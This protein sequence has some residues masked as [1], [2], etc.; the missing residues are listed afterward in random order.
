MNRTALLL[1]VV[2]TLII[3]P[4]CRAQQLD[5]KTTFERFCAM[6]FNGGDGNLIDFIICNPKRDAMERKKYSEY[7]SSRRRKV[8][9]RNIYVNFSQLIVIS[10]Y[11]IQSITIFKT[12]A[13][14]VVDFDRLV[15]TS[16]EGSGKRRFIKDI[17]KH[18]IVKYQ[19]RKVGGLWYVYDPPL[20]RV[21]IKPVKN[22]FVTVEKL[23]Q[24]NNPKLALWYTHERQTL[25]AVEIE[26]KSGIQ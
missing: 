26:V 24:K 21:S 25:E 13:T 5:P 3:F 4:E 20:P 16:G 7:Y 10:T 15:S 12:T 11:T 2:A 8:A 23:M 18:D 1:A 17:R 22:E 19:L 6:N 14:A 9:D